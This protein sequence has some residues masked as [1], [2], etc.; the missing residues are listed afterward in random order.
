MAFLPFAPLP[1]RPALFTLSSLLSLTRDKISPQGWALYQ[2]GDKPDSL[3]ARCK[4][5]WVLRV[6]KAPESCSDMSPTSLA[7][8]SF[9]YFQFFLHFDFESPRVGDGRLLWQAVSQGRGLPISIPCDLNVF[10][11]QLQEWFDLTDWL[12]DFFAVFRIKSGTAY[13]KGKLSVTELH[14]QRNILSLMMA[15]GEWGAWVW[16]LPNVRQALDCRAA[17]KCYVCWGLLLAVVMATLSVMVVVVAVVMAAAVVIVMTR[18]TSDMLDAGPH[19]IAE[20]H[21]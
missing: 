15:V 5:L 4:D 2:G 16:D 19:F 14:S 21:S 17:I 1:S 3:L 10:R 12:I 13:R 9:T 18:G 6:F 11:L 20:L 8:P 7:F